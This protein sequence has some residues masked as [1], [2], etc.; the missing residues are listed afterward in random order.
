MSRA[1]NFSAAQVLPRAHPRQ[2]PIPVTDSRDST[3]LNP[4]LNRSDT[5]ILL[6]RHGETTWNRSG[7]VQ[8]WQ[9]SP[10]SEVGVAQAQALAERFAGD[11]VE[12]L[13]SSDLGRAQDTAAPI[14]GRL[15][16]AIELDPGIRERNYG[17]LEGRTYDEIER[18]HPEAY[19]FL[20]RRDPA[21]VIPDGESGAGFGSRVLGAL[22]RIAA[23]H[24]GNRIAV[25]THG[26][27]L[28]ELYRHATKLAPDSRRD[29]PL[30]NASVNHVRF[31][32]GR[33]VIERWGDVA[34]L[35]QA[36]VDDPVD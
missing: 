26:G 22:E 3:P 24:S 9:D 25:V 19:A 27:V 6:I 32:S 31:G 2:Q 23:E 29:H 8:G 17:I 13:I 11:R 28:S 16:I 36:A 10:L 30:A 35:A 21:Y 1:G 7:R 15:G 12:R 5:A 20:R 18:D 34:H 33:W 14:A 4:L